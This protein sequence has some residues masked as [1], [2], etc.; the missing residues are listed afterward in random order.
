[1]SLWKLPPRCRSWHL[2]LPCIGDTASVAERDQFAVA[3]LSVASTQLLHYAIYSVSGPDDS[4]VASEGAA[5]S[6]VNDLVVGGPSSILQL[7]RHEATV[8]LS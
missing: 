3:A 1:M 4:C 8:L 6:F 2:L 7:S 5:I